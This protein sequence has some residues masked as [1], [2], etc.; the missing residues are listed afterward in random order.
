M[1]WGKVV[2]RQQRRSSALLRMRRP[3]RAAGTG[4]HSSAVSNPSSFPPPALAVRSPHSRVFDGESRRRLVGPNA[5]RG[6]AEAILSGSGRRDWGSD[7]GGLQ[8]FRRGSRSGHVEGCR[9]RGRSWRDGG[10]LVARKRCRSRQGRVVDVDRFF[11][12]PGSAGEDWSTCIALKLAL[13][14]HTRK[15]THPLPSPILR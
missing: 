10:T 13:F 9:G 5:R 12:R 8:R 15:G 2:E 14:I 7:G 6:M 3:G 11:R 4:S 1:V